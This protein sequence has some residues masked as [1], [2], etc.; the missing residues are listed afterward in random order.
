MDYTRT[1]VKRIIEL[2]CFVMILSFLTGC[3]AQIPDLSEEESEIIS[4]YAVGVLLKYDSKH[5]SRLTEVPM[6]EFDEG[7]SEKQE[8]ISDEAD[9]EELMPEEVATENSNHIDE[10]IVDVSEE[11]S[12]EQVSPSLSIEEYY[13]IDG[14]RF[15]Y[16]GYELTNE[17]PDTA[18]DNL[19]FF[20]ME[21]TEGM[22]LLVV[23]FQATNVSG[24]DKELSMMDYGARFRISVNGKV[25]KS[26]LTTMLMNDIQTFREV[27]SDGQTVD[28]VSVIEVENGTVIDTLE[29]IMKGKEVDSTIKIQ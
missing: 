28:L 29:F 8:I 17:Y 26:V 22:Q 4:E 15:Q 14:F 1:K 6:E 5:G 7:I 12:E 23:S 27:V 10:N 11:A 16:A 3:G 13:G 19:A 18:E 2:A 9:V 20:A 24:M 25:S 21:A